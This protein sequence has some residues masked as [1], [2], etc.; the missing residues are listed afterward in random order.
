LYS[1]A[2]SNTSPQVGHFGSFLD[3]FLCLS[4]ASTGLAVGTGFGEG[5]GVG[6]GVA[7]G[8]DLPLGSGSD[9]GDFLTGV[10][11]FSQNL[12]PSS[13]VSP[14]SPQNISNHPYLN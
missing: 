7:L 6:T 9:F 1:S 3:F 12:D 5:T 4:G 13:T 14:H 10:P 11:Q 2:Y 8:L